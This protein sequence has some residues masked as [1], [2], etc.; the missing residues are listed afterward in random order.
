MTEFARKPRSTF[1]DGVGTNPHAVKKQE[2][3]LGKKV[4]GRRQPGSG[5]F[6]WAKGDV[7]SEELMVSAKRTKHQSISITV[8]MLQ[9]VEQLAIVRGLAPAMAIELTDP[10]KRI[11]RDW[12]LVPMRVFEE[13]LDAYRE[14]IRSDDA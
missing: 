10:N 4:G 3:R 14:R 13:M 9:E 1:Y 2:R 7:R 11:E 12:V 8:D 6:E 5:S